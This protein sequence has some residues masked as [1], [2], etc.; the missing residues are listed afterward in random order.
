MVADLHAPGVGASIRPDHA[1]SEHDGM[2]SEPGSGCSAAMMMDSLSLV[3]AI[4]LEGR[5]VVIADLHAIRAAGVDCV[6][7]QWACL[8]GA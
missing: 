5:V 2:V 8:S 6:L 7:R 1:S 3:V 4:R